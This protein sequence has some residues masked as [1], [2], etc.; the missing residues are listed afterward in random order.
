LGLNW[1]DYGARMYDAQLGRWHVVDPMTETQESWTPYHY[2]YNNP[3]LRTDPDGRCP[4]G[5]CP[6]FSVAGIIEN[7]AKDLAVSLMNVA[8]MTESPI[9]AI[10]NGGH[11]RAYRDESGTIQVGKRPLPSNNKELLRNLG[12]DVM[13][14][15]NVAA[16]IAT[17][18]AGGSG[19]L[20]AK[21]GT[22]VA[23]NEGV[24][25]AKAL[26]G[27][28]GDAGAKVTNQIPTNYIKKTSDNGQGT[29]F[30]DPENPSGNN[31]RVQSGNPNSPNPAQQR[32]YV[33]QTQN[34]KTVDANGNQVNSKS[35]EAHIP[36]D[37]FKFKKQ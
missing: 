21:T 32:P 10:A 36:R 26:I 2:V 15:T 20:M 35:K 24:Q 27:P 12:S 30:T 19:L 17:G 9:V 13:D 3:V 29:K 11:T 31:V 18:G 33:K 7:T 22:Q 25:K 5:D 14:G 8:L 28:A 4:D 37:D 16:T 6:T 1:M 34:G 23:V